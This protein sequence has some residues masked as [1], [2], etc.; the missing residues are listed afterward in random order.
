MLTGTEVKS[1]R[2]GRVNLK[3]SF[4]YIKN[5]EV[6]VANMH[7]SPYEHGTLANKDPLR[8]RT[9]LLNKREL[10][11]VSYTHID[12]YKRQTLLGMAF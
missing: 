9:L 12:V 1:I 7:V 8:V 11:T 6:F 5:G 2:Q 10:R 3:D 4:A